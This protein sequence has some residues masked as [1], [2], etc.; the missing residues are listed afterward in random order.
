MIKKSILGF[1][2]TFLSFVIHAQTQHTLVIDNLDNK[3][4]TLYIG[5]YSNDSDFRKED[6]AV[7]KKIIN[8]SGHKTIPVVFENI[9]PGVYAIAI[10][11]DIN[12]NGKIDTNLLGIPKEKYGFSNNIYPLMRAATFKESAFQVTDKPATSTIRLK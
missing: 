4:G 10:F 11:F 7:L 5:W 1:L 2:I 12:G 9:P 6:K 3:K 8:V